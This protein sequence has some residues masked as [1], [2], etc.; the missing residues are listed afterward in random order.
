M[1]TYRC[2]RQP[3]Q[4]EQV[5]EALASILYS[6]TVQFGLDFQYSITGLFCL[7]P[8]SAGIHRRPPV[9]PVPHCATCCLPSPCKRLSRSR[10]TTEAPPLAKPHSGQRAAPITVGLGS[11]PTF[12]MNRLTGEVPSFSPATSPWVRRRH[13]PRPLLRWVSH[14]P[15]VAVGSYIRP[16]ALRTNPYP[17]GLGWRA[18]KGG[19]ITGSLRVTPFRLA[20]QTW[21][22]W[23]CHSTLSL[24]RLLPP[25]PA[26]PGSGCLQLQRAAATARWWVLASHPVLWRLVAHDPVC[27]GVHQLAVIQ[28]SAAPGVVFDDPLIPQTRN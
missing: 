9:F 8:R 1:A 26:L 19:S 3:C 17:P 25:S 13:S 18:A 22:V 15:R 4:V 21:S 6:P 20:C 12:T 28:A 7:G 23:R 24:S 27:P 11:V 14:L 16:R 10:T 2:V 5:V